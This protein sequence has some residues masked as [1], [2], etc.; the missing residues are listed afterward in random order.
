VVTDFAGGNNY[1][2]SGNIVAGNPRIVKDLL[3]STQNDWPENL[4]N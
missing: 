3:V 4:R 1:M 2:V